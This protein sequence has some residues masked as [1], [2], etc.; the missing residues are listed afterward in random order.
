MYQ[1]P[2]WKALRSPPVSHKAA[3]G[4]PPPRLGRLF[5]L[6][7]KSATLSDSKTIRYSYKCEHC[8]HEWTEV[9][10]TT[11]EEKAPEGYEGD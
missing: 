3:T 6:T 11:E 10:T 2:S 9:R 4:G 1:H 8:G 7:E 5:P